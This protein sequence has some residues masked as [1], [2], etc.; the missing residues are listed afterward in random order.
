MRWRGL[1]LPLAL[2]LLWELGG[3]LGLLPGDTL[4]RPSDIAPAWW[5]IFTDGSLLLA[6]LQTFETALL[7]L[8][9]GAAIGIAAGI[10]IGLSPAIDKVVSPTLEAL[11]PVPP[12]A[13]IP[14]ALLL[15]GF[16]V[17]MEV[18]VVAFAC[19]WP[20]LIVTVGAVRLV[21]ARLIEIG[22]LLETPLMRRI[23][24]LILPAALARIWVGIRVA[25]GIALVV[26]VTV[27][28]VLNPQG[29]GYAM[30]AAAQALHPALM[31]AELLWLGLVGWAF[32]TG[33]AAIDRHWL[34][35]FG[36]GRAP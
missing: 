23:F 18:L 14:L 22:R 19:I 25:A 5:Q 29:L 17:R 9:I 28:I 11:R 26:A 16:G 24:R 36:A 21:D 1:L 2:L 35:R 30:M 4:S 3:A 31:W 12:V 34:V 15:Y 33:L 7:G 13:L 20:V 10:A 8:A 27:E 6:T 32:N